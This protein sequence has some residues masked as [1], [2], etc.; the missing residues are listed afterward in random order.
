MTATEYDAAALES[1][2]GAELDAAVVDTEVLH[3]ALNLSIEVTTAD[4][5]AYVVRRPDKLRHTDL[6]NDLRQEY[7]VM[8]RLADTEIPAPKPVAYCE[9]DAVLGSPF[10]VMT[11]LEGESISVGDRLPER[12]RNPGA[13]TRIGEQLVDALAAVHSVDTDRFRGLCAYRSAREQVAQDVERLETATAA[14]GRERPVLWDV[15]EW[16]EANAPAEA[17]PALVHGDFK[18]GNV[19]FAGAETPEFSGVVDWETAMLGDP[20][21]ELGYV[22][23]YWQESGDSTPTVD[24]LEGDYSNDDELEYVSDLSQ[25]GLCPFTQRAGSPSRQE[26]VARY[27]R[28]TDIAFEHERFYRAHAAFGLATVWAD[29]DRHQ[30]EA[31]GDPGE[32]AIVEYMGRVARRIIDGTYGT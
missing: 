31:G 2:L 21:Q 15:A 5:T 26:L 32:G 6:V 23:L 20:R 28:H 16:L 13:R 30:L 24:D 14:T 1:Y 4:G 22:L 27:E 25:R 29:I 11:Y 10:F 8:T 17:E 19:F 12:F 9:D 18:P 3:Q 7:E